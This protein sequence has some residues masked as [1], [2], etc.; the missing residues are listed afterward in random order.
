MAGGKV[1][2]R[3]VTLG[4]IGAVAFSVALAVSPATAGTGAL[5]AGALGLVVAAGALAATLRAR[6]D[7]E[8][9]DFEGV[10]ADRVIHRHGLAYRLWFV[11]QAALFAGALLVLAGALVR[12]FGP[13]LP[14]VVTAIGL[15]GMA[16]QSLR[17]L[18]ARGVHAWELGLGWTEPTPEGTRPGA[19]YALEAL[20][21][22]ERIAAARRRDLAAARERGTPSPRFRVMF[23]STDLGRRRTPARRVDLSRPLG[24][25]WLHE[26]RVRALGLALVGAHTLV[27][28]ALASGGLVAAN[29]TGLEPAAAGDAFSFF[30][31]NLAEALHALGG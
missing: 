24:A 5:T 27:L 7:A 22:E 21:I 8:R 15:V 26:L 12:G 23:Q 2:L 9:M 28:G 16:A 10:P 17:G 31:N 13:Q 25:A 18:V 30:Q 3:A 11:A 6:R 20:T 4:C 29:A 19:R 14:V 1:H